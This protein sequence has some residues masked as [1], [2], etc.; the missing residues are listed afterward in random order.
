MLK[1]RVLVGI[2]IS[3]MGSVDIRKNGETGGKLLGKATHG[4]YSGMW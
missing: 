2:C 3:G 1:G 4:V